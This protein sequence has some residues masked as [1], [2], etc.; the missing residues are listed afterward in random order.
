MATIDY[1]QALRALREEI[2]KS[3]DIIDAN[4]IDWSATEIDPAQPG[5]FSDEELTDARNVTRNLENPLDKKNDECDCNDPNC[6]CHKHEEPKPEEGSDDEED[7]SEERVFGESVKTEATMNDI[8]HE[9]DDKIHGIRDMIFDLEETKK[10]WELSGIDTKPL[11]AL[12]G[13]FGNV[14]SSLYDNG[15]KLADETLAA[16]AEAPA[17]EEEKK[18]EPAEEEKTDE[19]ESEEKKESVE[20]KKEGTGNFWMFDGSNLAFDNE[21]YE[22]SGIESILG[23]CPSQYSWAHGYFDD[24]SY[25]GGVVECPETEDLDNDYVVLGYRAGYYEGIN[26]GVV[27]RDEEDDDM[28]DGFEYDSEKA[29]AEQVKAEEALRKIHQNYGGHFI[30]VRAQFS[31]GETLYDV[32]KESA[33]DAMLRKVLTETSVSNQYNGIVK[34]VTWTEVMN[35]IKDSLDEKY[36]RSLVVNQIVD[37]ET[38]DKAFEVSTNG[39][40]ID[41]PKELKINGYTLKLKDGNIYNIVDDK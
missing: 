8:P 34:N 30:K 22:E 21:E 3:Q 12:I 35:A 33:F 13:D 17:S 28:G 15:A 14:I 19:A 2:E 6:P 20:V 5:S 29:F 41:L 11:D 1:K 27:V 25:G 37:G 40:D 32:E 38:N 4:T 39:Q 23:Q 10:N 7:D 36:G 31:N 18:E 26:L 24:R 16:K 9:I